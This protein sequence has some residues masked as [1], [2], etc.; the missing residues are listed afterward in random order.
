MQHNLMIAKAD[1]GRTIVIIDKD[2]Y[3]WK[4]TDFVQ[5]NHYEQLHKDPTESYHKQTQKAIQDSNAL[6]DK[7]RRKYPAQIKPQAPKLN[8]QIKI[9][10]DNAPVRPVV[11]NI[12]APTYKL[13]KFL[14]KW[15]SETL[16]LPNAIVTQNTIQLAHDLNAIKLEETHKLTTFDIK[17]L[18]VNIPIEEVIQT[19]KTLLHNKKLDNTLQ[20][21][22]LLLHTILTQNYGQFDDKFYQPNKGTT[23]GSPLSSL[24]AEIFL[25]YYEDHIIKNNLENKKIIF[26]NRY[27]DN[28]LIIF[29]SWK[30]TAEQIQNY[31]NNICQQLKFKQTVEENNSINYLDLTLTRQNNAITINIF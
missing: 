10:R 29:D 18:Y 27:V 26:Y 8:A 4:V 20:Q 17:D 28:I 11:K 9:H 21:T 25:Q 15:L 7:Q 13:A 1:K 6:I 3:K 2:L 31:M 30:T 14:T 12:H 16:Q 23:M 24:I 22:I 19:T 5:E